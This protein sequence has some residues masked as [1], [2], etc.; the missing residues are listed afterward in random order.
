MGYDLLVPKEP[1]PHPMLLL[2]LLLVVLIAV[3]GYFIT[4]SV[5]GGTDPTGAVPR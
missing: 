3:W 4:I 2:A 5:T 1:H